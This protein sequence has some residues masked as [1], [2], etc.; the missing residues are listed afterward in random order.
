MRKDLFHLKQKS[1]I[2]FKSA[3]LNRSIHENQNI[4]EKKLSLNQF[5]FSENQAA[6]KIFFLLKLG[7]KM[8]AGKLIITYP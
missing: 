8:I 6:A 4:K 3:I 2:I 1:R 7:Y 5:L